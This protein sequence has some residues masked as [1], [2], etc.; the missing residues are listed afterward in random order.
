MTFRSSGHSMEP[1]VK[2]KQECLVMRCYPDE[3]EVGDVVLCT[4][5]GK[6]YL[7]LVTAKQ[8]NRFQISNNKGKVNGWTK[9]IH[10]ILAEF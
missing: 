7:H 4:V 5:K 2:H 10:G 1:R 9:K 6:Q 3:V 8:G